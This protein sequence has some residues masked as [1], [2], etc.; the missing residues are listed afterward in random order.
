MMYSLIDALLYLGCCNF[1]RF[2]YLYS[3]EILAYSFSGGMY[4]YRFSIGGIEL[5]NKFVLLLNFYFF[6]IF[7]EGL[8]FI[9]FKCPIVF[10]YK[11]IWFWAFFKFMIGWLSFLFLHD[12]IFV[13]CFQIVIQFFQDWHISALLFW[14]ISALLPFFISEACYVVASFMSFSFLLV[15]INCAK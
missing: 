9:H 7:Q 10:I 12:L 4:L 1:G 14:H 15:Y 6:E 11:I 3:A 2:L 5:H 13:S 8:V